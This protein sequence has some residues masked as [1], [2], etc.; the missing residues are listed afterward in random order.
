MIKIPRFSRDKTSALLAVA[1][2]I[3]TGSILLA[4]RAANYFAS[5]EAEVSVAGPAVIITDAAA[6]GGRAV[7]FRAASVPPPAP[8][9][10]AN[11]TVNFNAPLRSTAAYPFSGTISTYG[12]SGGSIPVSAKQRTMLGNLG[13]GLY[14]V[15]LKW[16]GGTIVSSA[17]G[18]SATISGDTWLSNIH[19]YGGIPMIVIGGSTDNSFTAADAANMVRHFNG[20]AS[21]RVA[22]WVI[23]NEPGDMQSYCALFNSAADAMR[24][25]DPAIKIAGPAWAYYSESVL[26][27]FLQ[28]AGGKVDIIDY[29]HYGMG[30]TFLSD[31]AALSQTTAYEDEVNRIRQL[32][33]QIVPA[34]ANNIEIQIGEYNWSWRTADG[35]NGYDGDDRFYGAITTVWGASVVGHTVRA[36]GRAHQYA[37]QNGA[38]GITFE[39]TA[40]A[41][42]FGTQISDPMPIYHGIKMFSGG[43]LFRGFGSTIVQTST[44]LGNIEVYASTNAKNIVLIN[45]DPNTAQT[46]VLSLT[47]VGN[48]TAPLWQTNK[49]APFAD[50]A[51][52][53]N[54]TITNGIASFSLPPYTVSTVVIP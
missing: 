11:V 52:K 37:D 5:S 3:I 49:A 44:S 30:E 15:P 29:H 16:N 22:Y 6:S 36:G 10:A 23:G 8:T 18:A 14:R 47:G 17:G 4:V 42:H 35:Y 19:A 41:S 54:I 53:G 40:D 20:S 25:V 34:R 2:V 9:P 38:L 1:A 32:I 51:N 7:Q 45:K 28:C 33:T 13:P 48:A 21:T 24:A 39:K 50:P 46:A 43:N 27:S 26:T 12:Q 31:A